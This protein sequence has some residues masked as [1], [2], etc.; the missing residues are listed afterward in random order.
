MTALGGQSS[1]DAADPPR[2]LAFSSRCLELKGDLVGELQLW[3][4]RLWLVTDLG[5]QF[6]VAW[7]EWPGFLFMLLAFVFLPFLMVLSARE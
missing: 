4:P 1:S 7:S 5:G 3:R 6:E 2:A